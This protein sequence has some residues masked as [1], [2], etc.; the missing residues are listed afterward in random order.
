M[1]SSPVFYPARQS[2]LRW[3]V[4]CLLTLWSFDSW[5][6][7][8]FS[9]SLDAAWQRLPVVDSLEQQ[10]LAFDRRHPDWLRSA[11]E[12]SV[13]FHQGDSSAGLPSEWQ[14]R[15]SLDLVRPDQIG[16]RHQLNELE[17]QSLQLQLSELRWQLSVQLQDWW[18][19]WQESRRRLLRTR[20]QQQ[21]LQTQI[22]WLTLLIEQGERPAFDLIELQQQASRLE[23]EQYLLESR[24]ANLALQFKQWTGFETVPDAWAFAQA[25]SDS[26]KLHPVLQSLGVRQQQAQLRQHLSGNQA[27]TPTVSVGV[28]H[29]EAI[30]S[31]PEANALQLGLSIPLGGESYQTRRDA[32]QH[33]AD[34]KHAEREQTQALER[35]RVVLSAQLPKLKQRSEHLFQ[36]SA[37]ADHQY[38]LQQQAWKDGSLPGFRWLQIQR[39]IWQLQQ[40]ADEAELDYLKS[41]SRWNQL[42]GVIPQ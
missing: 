24:S 18:W 14:A 36:L 25:D 6:A 10:R 38:Q 37:D 4:V 1:P 40:Q 16:A 26:P 29:L 34:L 32:I 30:Q 23:Q 21:A 5:S 39:S 22:D 27:Y 12:I 9:E 7:P 35:E 2:L 19:R 28:K 42:Q 13:D 41:I 17:Q 3:C 11:P 20:Q 31:V 15:L 33:T 8:S